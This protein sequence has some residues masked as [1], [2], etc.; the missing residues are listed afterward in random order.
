MYHTGLDPRTME[1]IHVPNE[2][3]KRLQRAL[4]QFNRKEN[5]SLVREALE[6]AGRNDLIG[7][8]GLVPAK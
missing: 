7:P 3:E 1:K 8:G 6:K 5:F 2:A 4:L